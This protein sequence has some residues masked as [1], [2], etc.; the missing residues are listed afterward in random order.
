MEKQAILK[1]AKEVAVRVCVNLAVFYCVYAYLG[2]GVDYYKLIFLSVFLALTMPLTDKWM[3]KLIRPI[4]VAMHGEE[5][6]KQNEEKAVG[7]K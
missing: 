7:R 4:A 3:K 6:V 2:E 1:Y 5:K